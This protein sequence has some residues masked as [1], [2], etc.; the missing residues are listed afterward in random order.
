MQ[1]R[2]AETS[3]EG[4]I[5]D[6]RTGNPSQVPCRVG[7]AAEEGESDVVAGCRS[8]RLVGKTARCWEVSLVEM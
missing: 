6:H 2:F 4:G 5:E 3:C 8:G 7:G 1:R